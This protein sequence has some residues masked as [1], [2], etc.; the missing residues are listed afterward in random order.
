[1]ATLF[2]LSL[3]EKQTTL[4]PVIFQSN[5]KQSNLPL[6]T[7]VVN[8]TTKLYKLNKM[9]KPNSL[10]R[11]FVIDKNL[12]VKKII[13]QNQLVELFTKNSSQTPLKDI[14]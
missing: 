5:F 9:L 1:M 2:L 7:V 10:N 4:Q 14:K 6:N 11:F 13:H 8:Q 12:N 3:C